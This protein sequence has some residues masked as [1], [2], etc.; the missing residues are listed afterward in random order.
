MSDILRRL[1]PT[2]GALAT[3]LLNATLILV[4]LCLWL[5]WMLVSEARGVA[6]ALSDRVSLLQSLQS[7]VAG[8]RADLSDLQLQANPAAATAALALR[9]ASLDDYLTATTEGITAL[10]ADPGLLVDGTVDRAA[11][12]IRRMV[13]RCVATGG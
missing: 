9:V 7:E 1:G 6:T 3:A 8:L 13:G 10:L 5:G 12:Q 4:A 11:L 2:L